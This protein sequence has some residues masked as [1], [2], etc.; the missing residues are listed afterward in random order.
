[1]Q[2][3]Y[4]YIR[5]SW[6]STIG[7]ADWSSRGSGQCVYSR[8][9]NSE[10]D[11]IWGEHLHLMCSKLSEGPNVTLVLLS[12]VSNG[13]HLLWSFL[14]SFL[15]TEIILQAPKLIC[16]LN[17]SSVNVDGE[18]ICFKSILMKMLMPTD[19]VFQCSLQSGFSVIQ[20]CD[21]RCPFQNK[22]N[23]LHVGVL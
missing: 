1:M 2:S 23:V 21:T 19:T 4:S 5:R 9:L 12:L 15:L 14:L 7:S 13:V 22:Q 16:K 6:C 11:L 18:E 3:I 10:L 17:Q 20:E 8:D